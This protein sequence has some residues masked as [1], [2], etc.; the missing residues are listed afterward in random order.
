MQTYIKYTCLIIYLNLFKE[1]PMIQE[2]VLIITVILMSVVTA[3]FAYVAFNTGDQNIDYAS[4][5]KKSYSIRSKF[6]WVLTIAGVIIFVLTTS[7]LPYS[8]TRG[9]IPADAVQVNV[10]GKQ[11]VW[12]MD[13]L[14]ANAG[15][16][17]VFNVSAADVTHGLGIYDPDM[18][19]IAQAQAMPSGYVNKIKLKLD[20]PGIYKLLCLEYCGLAHHSMIT[21]FT[22][23]PATEK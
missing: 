12:I 20:R 19:L 4:I 18:T 13:R 9:D 17:V 15:D 23:H 2:T 3:T 22:I 10:Q 1:S 6:F 11:W 14:E 7:D 8:A 16:T 21:D 5:Q